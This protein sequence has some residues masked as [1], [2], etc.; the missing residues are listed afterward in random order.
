MRELMTS[1]CHDV[2]YQYRL[3]ADFRRRRVHPT[4]EALVWNHVVG[5]PAER[6][7]LSADVA[8]N[9]KLNEEREL[10][11]RLSVEDLEELA[12]D[13][14]RLLAK[15]RTM[16]QQQRVLPTAVRL[17]GAPTDSVERNAGESAENTGDVEDV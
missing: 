6:L 14:E 8:M 10:F 15:A 11:A 2:D 7:Q 3:R 12:R 5:K 17:L 1:L 16:A 9:Q 4:I 13:S